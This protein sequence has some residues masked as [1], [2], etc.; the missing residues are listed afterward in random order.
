MKVTDRE[1]WRYIDG[2]CTPT[3]VSQITEA[4]NTNPKLRAH[5]KELMALH[6]QFMTFFGSLP[7][8]SALKLPTQFN[9][10]NRQN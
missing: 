7:L 5:L 4:L 6:Q 2:E 8:A 3:E 10:G 1:L 9:A